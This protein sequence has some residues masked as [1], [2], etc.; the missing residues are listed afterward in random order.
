LHQLASHLA[1]LHDDVHERLDALLVVVGGAV[2]ELGH[3]DVGAQTLV[4][5]PLDRRRVDVDVE[6]DLRGWKWVSKAAQ[7]V[8]TSRP[9]THL[10][11]ELILDVLLD[12]PEHERLEDHV[13]SPE[14]VLVVFAAA[15]LV[16]CVF[17]VAREPLAELVVRIEETRHD[18]V[19]QRP[20]LCRRQVQATDQRR[21]HQ[22]GLK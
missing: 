2:H 8:V 19:K 16:G 5:R 3:R 6:L 18:E 15:L 12:A 13:Q 11:A 4:H 7:T 10:V 20:E 1:Q 22:S 17:D 9:A 14:L 21:E